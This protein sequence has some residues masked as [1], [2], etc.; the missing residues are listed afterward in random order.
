[1]S[2][3]T[4]HCL[5]SPPVL[6]LLS[7]ALHLTGG[8]KSLSGPGG[9]I[10]VAVFTPQS[11]HFSSTFRLVLLHAAGRS[12]CSQTF[13]SIS[14]DISNHI[15]FCRPPT[16]SSHK[17]PYFLCPPG[18]IALVAVPDTHAFFVLLPSSI[19]DAP[20]RPCTLRQRSF[21]QHTIL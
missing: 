12:I 5:V 20:S 15:L 9:I 8:L 11:Q 2:S 13:R 18:P 7:P 14:P 16:A 4:N 19:V 21:Y 10:S 3:T 6:V 17:R 1:M